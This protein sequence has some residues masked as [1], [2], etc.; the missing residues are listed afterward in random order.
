MKDIILA[1][2]SPRRKELV[3][4]LPYNFKIIAKEVDE[5]F[6]LALSPQ[7]NVMMLAKQKA[8]VVANEHPESFVVGCDTVVVIDGIILGKPVD[9]EDAK[10]ILRL[11]SG[12]THTVFT[13][14]CILCA[15]ENV[16]IRFFEE[17]KVKMKALADD[18]IDWYIKTGEPMD[19]AGAYG[20]QQKGAIF[21]ERI[22]G[23]Y[24]NVVGLPLNRLYVELGKVIK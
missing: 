7:E 9:E 2:G 16:D 20:I 18:E 15:M 22:D 23:D 5:T 17:T 3:G 1:S 21:I 6:D 13:G 19:K 10:R 24:F 12:K 8:I 11:I 4:N 14:V